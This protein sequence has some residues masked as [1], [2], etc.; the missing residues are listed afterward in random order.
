MTGD[1]P[2][3]ITAKLVDFDGSLILHAQ[4]LTAPAAPDATG[5]TP[6]ARSN[7]FGPESSSPPSSVVPLRPGHPRAPER[8]KRRMA[9]KAV[10]APAAAVAPKPPRP[11][12][13]DVVRNFKSA[14]AQ[15]DYELSFDDEGDDRVT[16]CEDGE[17]VT[18]SVNDAT[19]VEAIRMLVTIREHARRI[20][21]GKLTKEDTIPRKETRRADPEAEEE[22]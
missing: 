6:R 9:K 22:P 12:W 5:V 19:L 4:K 11:A 7:V 15:L 8:P 1:P 13:A 14:D 2:K 20:R 16:I 3:P 17:P 10:L 21:S 18:L